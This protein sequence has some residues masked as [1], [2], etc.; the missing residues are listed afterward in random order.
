MDVPVAVLGELQSHHHAS[1]ATPIE[2]QL[3]LPGDVPLRGVLAYGNDVS[4]NLNS[5]R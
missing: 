4:D 2:H 1:Q 3:A 5:L